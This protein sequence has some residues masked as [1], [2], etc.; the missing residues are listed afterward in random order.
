[1]HHEENP[2]LP[3]PDMMSEQPPDAPYST[4]DPGE[5]DTS[6]E[7][8]EEPQQQESVPPLENLE[9][10]EEPQQEEVGDSG[11][12][13]SSS[14]EVIP[15]KEGTYPDLENRDEEQ[16]DEEE[17]DDEEDNAGGG[18]MEEDEEVQDEEIE[19]DEEV[20]EE[21]EEEEA[22]DVEEIE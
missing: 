21:E 22:D 8:A 9:P 17:E 6:F 3:S 12:D 16:E 19:E 14:L 4:S 15:I 2:P 5:I 7:L 1:M 10:P 13:E 11:D 18:M 20:E